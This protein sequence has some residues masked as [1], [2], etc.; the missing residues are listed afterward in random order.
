MHMNANQRTALYIF[1]GSVIAALSVWG[2]L[3]NDQG[4]AILAVINGLLGAVMSFTA[5]K[6]ITP[7][8]VDGGDDSDGMAR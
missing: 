3:S 6:N 1:A 5:V 8:P 7:D 2:V 4:D